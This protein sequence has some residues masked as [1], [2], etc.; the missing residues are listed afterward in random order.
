VLLNS[1]ELQF[2][3]ER[4]PLQLSA[5][6]LV[7]FLALQE[8]PLLRGYVAGTLWLDSTDK[9]AAGS[10]RSLLWRLRH[11]PRPLVDS[12]GAQLQL[13][14][15]VSVDVLE[16]TAQ[17]RE[18][19][20]PASANLACPGVAELRLDGDLLPDWYD[21]WVLIERERFRQL[22]VHA[23]ECL[24]E[25]LV[26]ARRFA[27]AAEAGLAAVRGEPLRES[28]HRAVVR[29]HIAEG[30]AAD[31]LRH[32]RLYRRLIGEQLGLPPSELMEELVQPLMRN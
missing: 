30:N 12:A 3:G 20:D 24:C 5:Q 15:E 29:V 27:D 11:L 18:L 23:L 19:L 21:D 1:F 26:R 10:L 9:R 14:P 22:R 13:A 6:R 16:A 2:D 28:A 17:A 31:A 7:A 4:V 32:Y 8:H 25:R